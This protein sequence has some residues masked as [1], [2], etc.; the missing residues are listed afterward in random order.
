MHLSIVCPTY[1]TWGIDGANMGGLSLSP[2]PIGGGQWG[3]CHHC[4]LNR[5]SEGQGLLSV[6]AC[7]TK[8]PMV[9]LGGDGGRTL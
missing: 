9:G 6:C 8:T 1:P 4:A 5:T 3:I 7:I 2:G